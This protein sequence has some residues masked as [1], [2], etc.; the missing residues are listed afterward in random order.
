MARQVQTL[1]SSTAGNRPAAGSRAPGELYSNWPDKQLGVID[2]TQNPMDLIAVRFFS[3]TAAYSTGD[4]V[5]QAGQL[6]QA[7]SNLSAGAFNATNWNKVTVAGDTQPNYTLKAGDTMTGPLVLPGDPTANLQAATKQYVDNLVGLTGGQQLAGLRNM[8]INGNWEIDQTF[9][10]QTQVLLSTGI[11]YIGDRWNAQV[12]QN[13][14]LNVT[15]GAS[16]AGAGV[17]GALRSFQATVTG[18]VPSLVAGDFF[19]L[20]QRI[21]GFNFARAG[22]GQSWG[23][24]I[25]VSFW[26]YSSIAG[27]FPVAIRNG[28]ANRSYVTTFALPATTWTKISLTIPPDTTGTWAYDNTTGATLSFCFGAGSTYQASAANAW[29]AGNFFTAPGCTNLLA[30]ASA[31]LLIAQVQVELGS[32]A[33]PYEHR[34]VQL[35]QILCERY[36]KR[37]TSASTGVV[38]IQG[39]NAAGAIVINN[40]MF[41]AMRIAPGGAR[42]GIIGT[43]AVTNCPQP[44]FGATSPG[45]A[46]IFTTAT[47][48]GGL[49]ATSPANGGFA[50]DAEL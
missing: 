21:E 22:F 36:H 30:T 26:A 39:Y 4:F 45:T 31:Q 38:T 41:P 46:Y 18:T 12:S 33:T 1:R 40:Y 16:L 20:Q 7:K 34:S 24:P 37:I 44:T 2:A 11:W 3:A 48:T 32:T 35:E 15:G 23:L 5:L 42:S 19:I 14:K 27:T 25:T 9:N 8:I 6:Y 50:L 29:S 13:S 43:W 49:V 47:A 17:T 28:A 10:F